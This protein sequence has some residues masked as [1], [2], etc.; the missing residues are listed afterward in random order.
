MTYHGRS[1]AGPYRLPQ[2]SRERLVREGVAVGPFAWWGVFPGTSATATIASHTVEHTPQ[3]L[4]D[5]IAAAINDWIDAYGTENILGRLIGQFG[6]EGMEIPRVRFFDTII[7]EVLVGGALTSPTAQDPNGVLFAGHSPGNAT[8]FNRSVDIFE[9]NMGSVEAGF[10]LSTAIPDT[11]RTLLVTPAIPLRPV[12]PQPRPRYPFRPA[13]GRT[14]PGP[15]LYQD[16]RGHH[17]PHVPPSGD[18]TA[19]EFTERGRRKLSKAQTPTKQGPPPKGTRERKLRV[20]NPALG[21]MLRFVWAYT[22]TQDVIEA[23]HGALPRGY[24]RHS[25]PLGMLQDI[26]S[27]I[28]RM[29]PVRLGENLLSNEILDQVA[30]RLSGGAGRAFRGNPWGPD[31]GGALPR[32]PEVDDVGGYE[33]PGGRSGRAR[34][35]GTDVFDGITF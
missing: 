2:M 4:D 35:P 24:Q 11:T 34:A 15:F 7:D 21:R 25:D 12:A 23:I 28:H 20:S 5:L 27:G 26:F 32:L 31:I 19:Y 9:V 3:Q 13:P 18:G 29:D 17:A 10:A 8:G 14:E 6:V 22:E 30:G 1:H 16:W 33:A